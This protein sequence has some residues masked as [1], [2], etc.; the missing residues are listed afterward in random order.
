MIAIISWISNF[1]CSLASPVSCWMPNSPIHLR[2][3]RSRTVRAECRWGMD[4]T[5]SRRRNASV[6]N[7]NG[8]RIDSDLSTAP[9]TFSSFP[10]LSDFPTNCLPF[11]HI[12][13]LFFCLRRCAYTA[14][15]WAGNLNSYKFP[16][17]FLPD[18]RISSPS[19][20]RIACPPT[21]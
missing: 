7:A 11:Y 12:L 21:L 16:S 17:R 6:D 3:L 9:F 8:N 5:S 19:P 20:K 1:R 18:F 14:R 2:P 4:T 10:T 15:Y 13:P